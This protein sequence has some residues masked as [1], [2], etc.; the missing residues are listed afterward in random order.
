MYICFNVRL[1]P[2]VLAPGGFFL[3]EWNILFSPLFHFAFPAL[4]PPGHRGT[5]TAAKRTASCMRE[6]RNALQH[7]LISLLNTLWDLG[8]GVRSIF[9]FFVA[10][11]QDPQ[12][13]FYRQQLRCNAPRLDTRRREIKKIKSFYSLW[14]LTLPEEP[15][16]LNTLLKVF[17]YWPIQDSMGENSSS[18]AWRIS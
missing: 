2:C 3:I 6:L 7:K 13:V 18:L 14:N 15:E 5:Q 4:W 9:F 16:A 1:N 12:H 8:Q 11:V 10:P 17:S